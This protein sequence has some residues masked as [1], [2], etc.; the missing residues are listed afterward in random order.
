LKLSTTSPDRP[1]GGND[2]HT[3]VQ[4]SELQHRYA[5]RCTA[6]GKTG[7]TILS[8]IGIIINRYAR[9]VC[10][11]AC[12]PPTTQM[13][14]YVR[15]IVGNINNVIKTTSGPGLEREFVSCE[16]GGAAVWRRGLREGA[17]AI[18]ADWGKWVRNE[19]EKGGATPPAHRI[20]DHWPPSPA[21]HQPVAHNGVVSSSPTGRRRAERHVTAVGTCPVS[22]LS[23]KYV[24]SGSCPTRAITLIEILLYYTRKKICNNNNKKTT[25]E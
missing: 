4:V 19:T 7:I 21:T 16:G 10:K 6:T 15:K 24:T 5:P 18:P 12:P 8:L 1:T 9:H 23:I 13:L 14:P 11:R 2:H 20:A 17:M 25:T 22:P 3:P